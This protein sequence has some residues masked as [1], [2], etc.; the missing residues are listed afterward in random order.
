MVEKKP[1]L[2]EIGTEEL[3]P[4]SLLALSEAFADNLRD[5][6]LERSMTFAGVE[7]FA[8]PRRLAVL[9]E[10]LDTREPDQSLVR[11]GPSLAA[12]FD[13]EGNPTKAAV[14]FA[15]SC[16]VE[17]AA[18]GREETDKGVWV[19]ARQ[20]KPGLPTAALVPQLVEQALARLPIPKRMRWGSGE[21]EFVRPV[22]WVVL[23]FGTEPIPGKVLGVSSGRDTHGHRFH[24]PKAIHLASAGSYAETLRT[25]GWVEPSF[26]ERRAEIAKQV[27]RSAAAEG[28]RAHLDPDLLD[29]VTALCEWPVPLVGRFDDRFLE[30][31][32][33]VL[34]ETMQ[35]HQKY[36]PVFDGA[37]ALLPRFVTISNLQSRDP[38]QVRAGN[39]RVI[40][41]RFTDAAFFWNQDRKRPLEALSLGLGDVVFQERLG[42]VAEKTARVAALARRIAQHIGLDPELAARA[43][44]LSKADL[45]TNMI[46]EFPSLQ[47][48]M[49][50]YYAEHAGENPSVAAAIREQYLPRK[51]GDEL[52]RTPCG[53]ALAIADRLDTLVGIFAIGQRPTG[54][55]DPYALRRAALG[56]LRIL[57]E[58]PLPL[59]LR[60]LLAL[61]AAGVAE[62]V[63]TSD[64]ATEVL[65]YMM[66]RLGGYYQERGI[67]GDTLE[68]VL[69]RGIG[70]PSDIDARVR[71]VTHF[72]ELP[73]AASLAA[74]NKRIRNILRRSSE[75][76]PEEVDQ[77]L[78]CEPAEQHLGERLQE[79]EGIVTPL[80][81]NADYTAAL[82][83]LAELKGPVDALFDQVMVNVEDPGLRRNRLALLRSLES[84][85]LQVADLSRLQ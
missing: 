77:S 47:G 83:A 32:S 5:L 18:L 50:R 76:L 12:A 65:D 7:P 61:A 55:K 59:D 15:A 72:R 60:E 81:H 1:L 37:G 13:A 23:L 9:V 10:R 26:G 24:H 67:P 42:T 51:A 74:A 16:G 64:A 6:L 73:Q 84:L 41:P 45:L 82:T 2:V 62:K 71:A 70:I 57:I 31:P 38:E 66:E 19:T 85:F 30:I 3:P 53:L 34:I 28:G 40:R 11:R 14:G 78:L 22:H 79:M 4:K 21:A 20:V 27:E 75:A 63:G 8:T 52:P 68:A 36:F 46:S 44:H 58:T 54:V 39:E 56:V 17:V 80:L 48:I 35:S 49:G 69:A 25:Q 43:A 33:E 29:E